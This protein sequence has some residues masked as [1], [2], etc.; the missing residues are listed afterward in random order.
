MNADVYH[1]VNYRETDRL[2]AEIELLMAKAN[3]LYRKMDAQT[4][5]G[6]FS[7]V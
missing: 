7:L 2:L 3:A 1:P 6:F 5:P 4:M